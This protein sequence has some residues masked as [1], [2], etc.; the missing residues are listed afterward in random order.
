[1]ATPEKVQ[2]VEDLTKELAESQGVYLADFTGLTVEKVTALRRAFRKSGSRFIVAKNTLAKRAIK[3]SRLEPLAEHF[4]GPT[5]IAY[6][7]EDATAPARVL[8]DF[9]KENEG[10]K[11]K[12]GYCEGSLLSGREVAQIAGLP[13][14]G[15]LVAQ[16]IGIVQGPM[17]GIVTTVNAVMTSLVVAIEEVRKKKEASSA[18]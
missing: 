15:V 8:A 4:R 9:G 11:V 7:L 14:K 3:G 16:A 5:G 6:S 12:A 18:S 17:R 2:V 13:T 1:M 10:F